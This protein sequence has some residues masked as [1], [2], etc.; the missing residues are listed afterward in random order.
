MST[1][2]APAAQTLKSVE[3]FREDVSLLRCDYV[4]NPGSFGFHVAC[5]DGTSLWGQQLTET[6]DQRGEPRLLPVI[7]A[8]KVVVT[9]SGKVVE[10]LICQESVPTSPN[11]KP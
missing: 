1:A 7:V 3:I 4:D 8:D 6:P 9:Q 5:P 2:T 10:E 11:E